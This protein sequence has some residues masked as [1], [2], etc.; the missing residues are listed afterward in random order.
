MN[1]TCSKLNETQPKSRCNNFPHYVGQFRLFFLLI[2]VE[3]C[4]SAADSFDYKTFFKNCGLAAKSSDEVK[5]A[6]AIIDQDNSGF[7]EEEELK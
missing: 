5:K 4:V 7:I 2:N 1:Q 6:F 3:I